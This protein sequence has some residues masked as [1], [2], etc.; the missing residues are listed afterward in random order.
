[1]KQDILSTIK[2]IIFVTTNVTITTIRMLLSKLATR[3]IILATTV[4]KVGKI[5]A[6]LALQLITEH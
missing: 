2:Q 1:M 5:N 6:P 3:V 4:P